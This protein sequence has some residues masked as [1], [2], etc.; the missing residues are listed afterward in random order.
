MT[1]CEGN[2]WT[3]EID[4][5]V[6]A[7]HLGECWSQP[8]RMPPSPD[9]QLYA[10]NIENQLRLELLMI[11]EPAFCFWSHII[12]ILSNAGLQLRVCRALRKQHSNV[13]LWNLYLFSTGFLLCSWHESWTNLCSNCFWKW[14]WFVQTV[15]AMRP[16]GIT[17]RSM[18]QSYNFRDLCFFKLCHLF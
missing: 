8:S 2:Y 6:S 9:T 13:C 11:L 1:L 18:I 16:R 17:K 7:R 4:F 10:L 12:N 5:C 15:T 14:D 3:Q